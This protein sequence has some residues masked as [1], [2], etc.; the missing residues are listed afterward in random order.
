MQH[1]LDKY[2]V[3]IFDKSDDYNSRLF[4]VY[5][6][7]GNYYADLVKRGTSYLLDFKTAIF[8]ESETS[9]AISNGS[10][11]IV[12]SKIEV[13]DIRDLKSADI[14]EV[15]HVKITQA[16]DNKDPSCILGF[17]LVIALINIGVLMIA[18][19]TLNRANK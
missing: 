19:G 5:S 11:R 17:L 18:I 4:K 12:L 2:T 1:I 15:N 16:L 3:F 13:S 7:T 10:T 14:A 8:E 6:I 9:I